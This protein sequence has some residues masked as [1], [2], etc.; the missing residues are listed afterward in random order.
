[1]ARFYGEVGFSN[2]EVESK[3]G[4]WVPQITAKN[5]GGDVIKDNHRWQ[6]GE[7]L[8][9]NLTVNNQI[10]IVADP[11]AEENFQNMVYVKWMGAYWKVTNVEVLR[12]RLILSIGGVYNGPKGTIA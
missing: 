8:N 7:N 1:M 6:A 3:P 5:Y 2:G 10:S 11:F 9:D 4:V 12:P